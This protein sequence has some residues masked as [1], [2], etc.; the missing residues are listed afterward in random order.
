MGVYVYLHNQGKIMDAY[1]K[2]IR[3]F[4][5]LTKK[6]E[7]ELF[8]KAHNGDD[9]AYDKLIY[10]NLKFV[11]SV[12]KK[13]QNQGLTLEDLICEGN[14]GLVKAYY[15]F[16]IGKNVKFITYAVWWIRQAIL[17]AIHEQVKLI[18][19]PLNKIANV[20]KI[21]KARAL[22]EAELGGEPSDYE[23]EEYIND[24]LV[25]K[26]S[27]YS[28]TVISLDKPHTDNAKDLTN[29]IPAEDD[30]DSLAFLEQCF[31]EELESILVKD[32]TAKERSIVRMYYGIGHI[33]PYT[34]KE[35]GIDMGLTRERIRQ[36]KEKVLNKLKM[37]H[38]SEKLRIFL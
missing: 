29:I 7:Q 38:R 36:I 14:F 37:K 32:F 9:A 26:D 10:S 2:L 27:L 20:T 28:H 23:I 3:D 12:A 8:K 19:I 6:Q 1:L 17:N 34:L 15:K 4:E 5:P 31:K 25:M 16:D 33:R 11:I 30:K 24:P 21:A 18:R 22:L 35:I 13:Y